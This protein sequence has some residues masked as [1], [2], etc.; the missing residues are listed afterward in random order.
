MAKNAYYSYLD[1]FNSI[2]NLNWVRTFIENVATNTLKQFSKSQN[3]VILRH[4][5]IYDVKMAIFGLFWRKMANIVHW[6]QHR[7][8]LSTNWVRRF[9]EIVVKNAMEAF[10]DV[11]T[12][13][14]AIFILQKCIHCTPTRNLYWSKQSNLCQNCTIWCLNGKNC[15][16]SSNN[17]YF[18]IKYDI[19]CKIT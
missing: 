14:G 4:D 7:G 15:C 16:F 17:R 18:D 13:N 3:D 1:P 19:T 6:I 9:I 2:L 8:N 5:V 10:S 12:Q 11:K